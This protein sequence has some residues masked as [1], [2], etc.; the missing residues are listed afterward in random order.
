MVINLIGLPGAGKTTI[1]ESIRK[2]Y[3]NNVIILEDYALT[4]SSFVTHDVNIKNDMIDHF[5]KSQ[6]SEYNLTDD[7]IYITQ[8]NY[9][10]RSIMREIPLCNNHKRIM[11]K[12]INIIISPSH[13][14]HIN[15][16]ET[17]RRKFDYYIAHNLEEYRNLLIY[18]SVKYNNVVISGRQEHISKMVH[19]KIGEYV[20]EKNR[21][22]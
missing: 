13:G 5:L 7:K 18:Q 21:Y 12:C 4:I 16:L 6:Y 9:A 2:E 11:N 3:G 8:N 14:D 17:R 15:N 1:L 20:N 22:N 10:I 19:E